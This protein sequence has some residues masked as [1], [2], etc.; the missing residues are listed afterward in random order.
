[1]K[2]GKLFGAALLLLLSSCGDGVKI[3]SNKRFYCEPPNKGGCAIA[4]CD[5]IYFEG[6]VV[7]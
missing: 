7:E 4:M 5:I 6:A 1:M 3:P 2:K